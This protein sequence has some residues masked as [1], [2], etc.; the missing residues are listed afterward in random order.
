MPVGAPVSELEHDV[1]GDQAGLAPF[2]LFLSADL[3]DTVEI[4]PCRSCAPW[5]LEVVPNDGHL[6]VREW[7][8]NDCPHLRTLLA[9]ERVDAD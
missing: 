7:H 5:F 2:E 8:A 1:S 3:S 6:L 4:Q 9:D